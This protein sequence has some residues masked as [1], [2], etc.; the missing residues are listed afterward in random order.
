MD[1]DYLTTLILILA[2]ITTTGFFI[3][4]DYGPERS[5]PGVNDEPESP[6]TINVEVFFNNDELDPE[7][8]CDKVFSVEREIPQGRDIVRTTLEELLQGPSEQ[9]QLEGYVT[10]INPGVKIQKLTIE[11]GMIEVDFDEQLEFEVGGACRVSAIRAQIIETLK[12][13]PGINDVKI[14]INGRTEDI[15]QP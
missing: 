15:L 3:L 11:N 12:Q 8:S 7:F 1:K 6:Q 10:N 14:S 9:E 2:V 13:F 5:R 4:P